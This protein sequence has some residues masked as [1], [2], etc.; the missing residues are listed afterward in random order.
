M[1]SNHH[2]AD[3]SRSENT[4]VTTIEAALKRAARDAR[5]EAARTGTTVA[6]ARDGKVVTERPGIEEAELGENG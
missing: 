4:T 3:S 2:P 1:K 6:Y 5:R